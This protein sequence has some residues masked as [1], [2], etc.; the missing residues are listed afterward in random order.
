MVRKSFFPVLLVCV[1]LLTGCPENYLEEKALTIHDSVLTVD[2]HVD[3]PTIFTL[4]DQD[5]DLSVRHDPH[6]TDTKVDFPRMQDGGIDAIFF[7]AF[8]WQR[9]RTPEGNATAIKEAQAMLDGIHN[10]LELYPDLAELALTPDDA[11]RLEKD[12]KR[13][14]FICI[15]NGYAIGNDLSLIEEY[16]D[17]GV[18]YMGLC[19][20]SNNDICDSSTDPEG[21]EHDGLSDF[22]RDVVA[23]MNRLGMMVDVSHIS[24]EAFYDVLEISTAPVIA[25]HSGTRAI[26]DYPRHMNDDM[27]KKLAENGGVIQVLF[28]YVI[29][30]DSEDPDKLATVADVVDHIDH[31]V[32]VAG[33]DHVGIGSD[34]DGGGEVEGCFDVSEMPNITIELVKRGYSEDQIR[35]IWG[36]NIM[37]VFKEVE[38]SAGK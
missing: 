12:G 38:E 37:R 13:A 26:Y 4:V 5:F 11:Y 3:T 6:Q 1:F 35:K 21:P 25:S 23:E 9:E 8:V 14:V 18:R 30:P 32:E 17:Q 28:M 31:I 34:F 10:N 2:T 7:A 19:H 24:D 16:Y 36:G 27:L 33:I 15:E 22:G 20:F 29:E